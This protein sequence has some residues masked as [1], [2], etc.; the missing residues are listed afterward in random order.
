MLHPSQPA[1]HS[2]TIVSLESAWIA[3]GLQ[4]PPVRIPQLLNVQLT[5]TMDLLCVS[6]AP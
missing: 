2:S 5:F 4:E 1:V 3:L 6:T